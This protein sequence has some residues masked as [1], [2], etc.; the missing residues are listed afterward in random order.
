[1]VASSLLPGG[2]RRYPTIALANLMF[3]GRRAMVSCCQE[4]V[5]MVKT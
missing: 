2:P 5:S 4:E 3:V 1:M